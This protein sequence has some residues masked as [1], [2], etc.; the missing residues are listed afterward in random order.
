MK[1]LAL[2][3]LT[4]LLI[5]CENKIHYP[6]SNN[7]NQTTTTTERGVWIDEYGNTVIDETS[8]RN[9]NNYINYKIQNTA[10]YE[11]GVVTDYVSFQNIGNGAINYLAF[12]TIVTDPKTGNV[13]ATDYGNA[14]NNLQPGYKGA[15]KIMVSVPGQPKQI[16]Y[17]T[18]LKEWTYIL[19]KK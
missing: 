17:R 5:G 11:Y 10:R 16:Q 6:L 15:I 3:A 4:T 18:Q 8:S 14:G 12:E 19:P 9:V 13:I 7:S 1:Q 2:L